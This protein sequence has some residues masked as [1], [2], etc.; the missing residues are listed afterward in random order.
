[1]LSIGAGGLTVATDSPDAF[2]PPL[3]EAQAAVASRVGAV[4]GGQF[5]ARYGLTRDAKS[6]AVSLRLVMH[7][8]AGELVL[9]RV[10]PL[11]ESDCA[12]AATVMA[13]ILERYFSSRS[14]ASPSAM[15][16]PGVPAQEAPEEVRAE[17][18]DSEP[19]DSEPRDVKAAMPEEAA[20]R[21]S[22][23]ESTQGERSLPYS[24]RLSLAYS[25]K[26]LRLGVAG[27]V[28]LS[29]W[30]QW[31]L[32]ANVQLLNNDVEE[33]GYEFAVARHALFTAAV[34]SLR[35]E[36][37]LRVF[38][39]PELGL[40]W[41][42]AQ[43][44]DGALESSSSESRLLP[45]LG[46]QVGASF[47]ATPSWEFGLFGRGAMGFAG[48]RFVVETRQGESQELFPLPEFY[49]QGGAFTSLRF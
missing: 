37:R 31:L 48:R 13:L 28:K 19:N 34:A 7:D 47:E 12:D 10:L 16:A 39:G 44:M 23:A 35:F 45:S 25:P 8:E 3:E 22:S 14:T 40:Q 29:P 38:A 33:A 46:A 36:P 43:A 30:W 41:E 24:L 18:N 6:G 21:A 26:T 32:E 42:L 15:A 1:M 4:T 9:E 11:S 49:W 17:P 20:S 5:E 27:G 2:C